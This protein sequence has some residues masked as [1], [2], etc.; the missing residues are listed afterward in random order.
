[1][2][3]PRRSDSTAPEAPVASPA[4]RQTWEELPADPDLHEDLG[5]ELLDLEAHETEVDR[6]L[7]LPKDEDML[8]DEAFIVAGEGDVQTL[9]E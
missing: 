1:M 9:G 4:S 5:Y 3:D 6:V 7:F 8:R 2:V